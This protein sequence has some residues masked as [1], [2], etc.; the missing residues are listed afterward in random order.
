[1]GHNCMLWNSRYTIQWQFS[2]SLSPCLLTSFSSAVVLA[3]W[4]SG[5]S[6]FLLLIE[7]P[8]QFWCEIALLTV[9]GAL[10]LSLVPWVSEEQLFSKSVLLGLQC[11]RKAML[12]LYAE[13]LFSTPNQ[14]LLHFFPPLCF[15]VHVKGLQR[16]FLGTLSPLVSRQVVSDSFVSVFLLRPC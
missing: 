9:T 4:H 14:L 2:L 12:F 8:A 5:D 16:P 1:M 13:T 6:L 15:L 11:L 3:G 10:I 7:L